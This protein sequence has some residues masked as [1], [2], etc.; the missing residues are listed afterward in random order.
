MVTSALINRKTAA[1][2]YLMA[3]IIYLF[4]PLSVCSQEDPGLDEILNG[5]E[6]EQTANGDGKNALDGFEEEPAENN[7]SEELTEDEILE[8]FEDETKAAAV[9]NAEKAHLP[10]WLSIDGYFKISSV[11]SYLSHDAAGTDTNWHGLSRLRSELKLE[12]DAEL[13]PDWQARVSGHGFYDVAY[14]IAGRDN[15]SDDVLDNYEKELEFDEV[16]LLGSLTGNL[17]LKAGRQ[18]V[19]WG[20]SD[21]IRI[22]DVLNPL[23]LRWPGLVDIEKL[24]LPVT[25]T[26]LDYYIKGWSLS[27][28]ALHEVR[29]N[30]NPEF[31]SD[32]FPR[33]QPFPGGKSPDEG[34]DVD[35]T[36]FAVSLNGIFQGWD[37]SFYVADIYA[38]NGF[39]SQTSIFPVPKFE[40][41]HARIKMLGGAFNIARGNWLLKAEAAYFDGFE[42]SNTSGK[43]YSRLDGLAGVE[44]SGI[45]DAIITLDIANRHYFDFDKRLK[46]S[47]DFQKEDLIEWALRI[48][49]PYLNDTLKLTFLANTFG[50][51]GDDGAIQRFS[52]E[53]DYTDS[54]QLTGGIVFYQSGDLRRTMGIGDNDR[55]FL[56]VQYS[57]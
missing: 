27:G 7:L 40:V 19:V 47:P 42:F 29:Y 35:N 46:D 36:Q 16:Y 37:I 57:F 18:I 13:S 38:Q 32:F 2:Y 21:N 50:P 51:S 20:R 52:A 23:D 54:I 56:D 10:D 49:K 25:M 5:F 17:D 3:L 22:T 55:V 31:G 28:I 30:K 8:G 12:V 53:Y 33:S 48:T 45:S 43:D 41:K 24:R 15:Y 14:A 44:Y 6:D 11:Y 4:L 26:K 39:I 34:F 1:A 9:S